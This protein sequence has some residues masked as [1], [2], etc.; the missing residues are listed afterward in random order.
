MCFARDAVVFYNLYH[1]FYECVNRV[2]G[3]ELVTVF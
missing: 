2:N 1:L 3:R